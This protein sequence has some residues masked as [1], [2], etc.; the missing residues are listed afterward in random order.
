[1]FNHQLIARGIALATRVGCPVVQARVTRA[2]AGLAVAITDASGRTSTRVV[3]DA[4][5]VAT[6]IESW[7][8]ADLTAPLL[9]A[10]GAE[11]SLPVVDRETPKD[12]GPIIVHRAS[13]RPLELEAATHLGLAS[14]ASLWLDLEVG[15]CVR[16]R[17]TCLGVVARAAHDLQLSGDSER[18]ETTRTAADLLVTVDVAMPLGAATVTIGG[19]V[20]AGWIHSAVDATAAM[21]NDQVDIDGGGL[22]GDGHVVLSIPAG[23]DLAIDLGLSLDVSLFA[24]TGTFIQDGATLTGEPRGFGRLGLGL[25]FGVP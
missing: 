6:V 16:L 14:D 18:M 19:G 25:R 4:T 3:A 7:T 21:S 15:A 10:R 20:G 13:P 9:A 11:D 24:H 1:M 23:H 8:R 17:G 5:A 12:L 22:R 2:A